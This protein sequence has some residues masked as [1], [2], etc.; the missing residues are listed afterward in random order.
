MAR[1]HLLTK[2]DAGGMPMSASEASV[3]PQRVLG[4]ALPMPRSSST[5]CLPATAMNEPAQRKRQILMQAW[6]S[7]CISA[8]ETLSAVIT[9]RP[10]RI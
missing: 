8:P 10:T 6:K 4:M 3:K 9:N 7:T 2:P 1:Y 5:R